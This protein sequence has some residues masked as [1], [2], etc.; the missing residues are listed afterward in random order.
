M[1][2][3]YKLVTDMNPF[4]NSDERVNER[5]VERVLDCCDRNIEEKPTVD[6]DWLLQEICLAL[7][8]PENLVEPF[9]EIYATGHQAIS[10]HQFVRR[11]NSCGNTH[12][13]TDLRYCRRLDS[14]VVKT[15][16]GIVMLDEPDIHSAANN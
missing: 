5:M 11:C 8:L 6:Y 4:L 16:I 12:S 3:F 9:L 14:M 13:L 7:G 2:A 10:D 15:A 1:Q